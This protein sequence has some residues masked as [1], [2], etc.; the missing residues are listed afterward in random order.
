MRIGVVSNATFNPMGYTGQGKNNISNNAMSPLEKQKLQLQE[1]IKNI[2]ESN[3]SKESKDKSIKELQKKLEELE[4][5]LIE[6]KAM[7]LNEKPEVKKAK[8][9][10]T[11]QQKIAEENSENPEAINK[12]VIMGITS[13]SSHE[14]IGK[15]AYSVYKKAKAK[16][17]MNTAQRALRYTMSEIKESSKSTKLIERGMKEYK[18]QMD[19]LKK[20]GTAEAT[21]DNT[22]RENSVGD[23]VDTETTV[24]AHSVNASK[25]V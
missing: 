23:G 18:K 6:E 19:N 7:K 3:S 16:G 17:D 24:K 8:D 13:A 22:I 21:A 1:Q 2:E 15:V 11:E 20:D 9:K 10:D 12:E 14:K 25:D 4:K 5:Q